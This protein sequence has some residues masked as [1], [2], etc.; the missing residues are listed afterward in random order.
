MLVMSTFCRWG[1]EGHPTDIRS[2][3]HP[4]EFLMLEPHIPDRPFTGIRRRSVSPQYQRCNHVRHHLPRAGCG[5]LRALC[6]LRPPHRANLRR[7]IMI[8]TILGLAVALALGV[9]LVVTLVNPERF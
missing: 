3:G 2:S 5:R 1:D 6:L 7:P 9:Y 4:Y 8:E